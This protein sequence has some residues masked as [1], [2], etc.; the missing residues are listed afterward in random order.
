MNRYHAPGC[1][2]CGHGTE[3]TKFAESDNFMAICNI[4][5]ILPGHSLV[6]PKWHVHGLMHLSNSELC[7]MNVF[8]RNTM[9]VLV[10]AFAAD[11][12]N[13][14]IQD[15]EGAGQT[16]AHLHLHLI[17]RTAND[18]PNPDDW[19][20]RLRDSPLTAT[21]KG[22]RPILTSAQITDFLNRVRAAGRPVSN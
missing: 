15:G 1:P 17:P 11:S 19:N 13:W 9:S 14:T 10:K 4:S 21:T 8:A 20:L 7:E 5:P 16:V 18:L 6:I 22:N 2:F 3:E 12:F